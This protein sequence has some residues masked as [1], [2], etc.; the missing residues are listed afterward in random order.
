MMWETKTIVCETEYDSQ[1]GI[2]TFHE[3]DL[4][5]LGAER[6]EF[7]SAVI[8]ELDTAK[9]PDKPMKVVAMKT[10]FFFKRPRG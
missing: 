1:N 5:A 8:D 9:D 2:F 4:N 3:P 10:R 7:V 6:W